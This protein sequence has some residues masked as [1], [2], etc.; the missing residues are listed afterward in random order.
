MQLAPPS[1]ALQR[2]LDEGWH[3]VLALQAAADF[4]EPSAGQLAELARLRHWAT[5]AVS[6]FKGPDWEAS[7]RNEVNW[8]RSRERRYENW[9]F[10]PDDSYRPARPSADARAA[11]TGRASKKAVPLTRSTLGPAATVLGLRDFGGGAKLLVDGCKTLPGSIRGLL[12]AQLRGAAAVLW[13]RHWAGDAALTDWA[14]YYAPRAVLPLMSTDRTGATAASASPSD[15]LD[16]FTFESSRKGGS[17]DA[18][19]VCTRASD[20]ILQLGLCPSGA[21]A[22]STAPGLLLAQDGDAAA[23]QIGAI[24]RSGMRWNALAYRPGLWA[25]ALLMEL[26]SF[27]AEETGATNRV[28][29]EGATESAALAS[30]RS[31]LAGFGYDVAVLA[32][33]SLCGSALYSGRWNWSLQL[34]RVISVAPEPPMNVA[35]LSNDGC[36]GYDSDNAVVPPSSSAPAG[37]LLATALSILSPPSTVRRVGYHGGLA[38]PWLVALAAVWS[39]ANDAL[40]YSVP[41]APPQG[42]HGL[43]DV[44]GYP[45]G[46]CFFSRELVRDV[47]LAAV[48]NA[49]YHKARSIVM[50]AK[51]QIWKLYERVFPQIW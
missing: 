4:D 30:V 36:S 26:G 12:F 25:L 22:L 47:A 32:P 3:V 5:A 17:G 37:A 1:R 45:S 24:R 27:D 16:H 11:D 9:T 34:P 39:G 44:A 51:A 49:E 7:V 33:G 13:L 18:M 48:F 40:N 2:L 29:R 43:Y 20:P 19:R 28:R 21:V 35:C 41:A 42:G 23:A 31:T 38:K 46:S 14:R 10:D 8:T 50:D 15:F 6:A